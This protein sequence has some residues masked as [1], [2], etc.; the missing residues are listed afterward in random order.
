MLANRG[1]Y[2]LGTHAA[3]LAHP[4]LLVAKAERDKLGLVS[5]LVLLRCEGAWERLLIPAFVFFFKKLYPF[6]WVNDRRRR[7]AGAA[8]GC[9]LVGTAALEAQGGIADIRGEIIDDCA[10]AKTIKPHQPIWLGLTRASR[11]LRRYDRLADVWNMVARTAFVQL[12][13]SLVLV[14][15]AVL[16]MAVVYLVP[17]TA[18]I[19]GIATGSLPLLLLG[20]AAWGM[21][22]LSLRPTL[23]LF[24]LSPWRGFL[25]PIAALLYTLMTIASAW[26]SL[27][28]QGPRWKD[29][30]Y[31]GGIGTGLEP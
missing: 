29:R 15:G 14:A 17:P 24:N 20:L 8:G 21:M 19:V 6:S 18:A 23:Q 25:L 7:T 16:A 9:M 12:R 30:Q 5:Q 26:R 11:S 13:H 28:G 31:V 2:F 1:E 10:L 27:S 4:A 3:P 22:V